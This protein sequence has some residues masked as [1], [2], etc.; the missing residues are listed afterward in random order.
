[1]ESTGAHSCDICK[2]QM[3]AICGNTVGEEGYGLKIPCYLWE[4]EEDV[5]Y[6]KEN[7]AKHRNRS[8]EKNERS[9]FEEI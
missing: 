5:K 2:N 9:F 7:A 6:Q 1:M 4:K 8:A 3:P